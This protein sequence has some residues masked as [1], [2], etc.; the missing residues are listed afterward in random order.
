M[1][2]GI[3][4]IAFSIF[5]YLLYIGKI[6]EVS[7]AFLMPA[8]AIFGLVLHGF[9]RLKELDL[10]NLRVVLNEIKETQKEIFVREEKLK[11]ISLPLAQ[12]VAFTAASEGRI[13]NKEM[14][15]VKRDW[16]KKKLEELIESL[17]LSPD[18]AEDSK[19]F[20]NKYEEIDNLLG[21][22]E[23]LKTSDE[24]YEQIKLALEERRKELLSMIKS[25]LE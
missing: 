22:R 17:E 20:I 8:T 21:N 4:A 13:A 15:S 3:S 10:K 25:D 18:D 23:A 1:A 12:M 9:D 2:L 6:G 16:Y 19:K 5:T 11:E 7:Y 24:D 14:W